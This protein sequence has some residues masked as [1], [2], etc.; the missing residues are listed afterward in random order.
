MFTTAPQRRALRGIALILNLFLIFG[1]FATEVAWAQIVVDHNTATT[2]SVDGNVTDVRTG[3]VVDSSGINSFSQFHVG[4]DSTVNLHLP[5]GTTSLVNLVHGSQSQIHGLLN[6]IQ[7]DGV[8][9]GDV[10]FLNPHG[11]I[12]GEHGAIN[13]GSLTLLTPT[14]NYMSGFFTSAGNVDGDAWA[15]LHSG[16]VP[17]SASGSITVQ[18]NIHALRDIALASGNVTNEGLITSGAVFE[19]QAADFSDVV[20]T[21]GVQGGTGISIE[22]GDIVIVAQGSVINAGTIATD[23]APGVGGA[24]DLDA[25]SITIRAGDSVRLNEDSLLSAVGNAPNAADGN[26]EIRALREHS[27]QLLDANAATEI[28]V[29]GEIRAGNI[30]L[31]AQSVADHSWSVDDEHDV[32]QTTVQTLGSAFLGVNVNVVRARA[33]RKS[34]V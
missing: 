5:T 32:F 8:I 23:G 3:T 25:G 11:V 12:V 9:G 2:L 30:L 15:K 19:A 13:V 7:A 21:A 34:V 4:L 6:A 33:D 1:H 22:N 27:P 31:S 14:Q 18:G 16:Q 10:Y 29:G 20:N 28:V 26:V 17:I 24:P